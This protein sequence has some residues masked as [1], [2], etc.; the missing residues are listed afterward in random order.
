[1]LS[2]PSVQSFPHLTGI[3]VTLPLCLSQNFSQ[4]Q[5]PTFRNPP[6]PAQR[7]RDLFAE[8]LNQA[9][10]AAGMETRATVLQRVFNKRSQLPPVTVHAARKWLMGESIPAHDRLQSLA[11]IVGVS[12]SWLRFGESIEDKSSKSLSAQEQLLIKYYRKLGREEQRHILAIVRSMSE[13][14]RRK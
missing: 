6:K 5:M 9:L 7:E 10:T 14:E 2:V 1:M 12:A 4:C 8:R 11:T 13:R 3:K